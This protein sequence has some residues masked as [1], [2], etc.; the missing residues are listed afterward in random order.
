MTSWTT[1]DCAEGLCD[2]WDAHTGTQPDAADNAQGWWGGL[3]EGLAEGVLALGPDG[4]VVAYNNRFHELWGTSAEIDLG[5]SAA[6]VAAVLARQLVEPMAVARALLPA[7]VPGSGTRELFGLKNGK[8]LEGC[9]GTWAGRAR[10]WS[11]RDVTERERESQGAALLARIGRLLITLDID[12]ALEA[13]AHA[14]LPGLG[15]LCAIDLTAAGKT[16]R[17]VEVRL[18]GGSALEPACELATTSSVVQVA[19]GPDRS[20]VTVPIVAG[21]TQHGTLTLVSRSHGVHGPRE[22]ILCQEVADRIA[23]AIDVAATNRRV[24]EELADRERLLYVAAHELRTPLSS[25]R[26]SVEALSRKKRTTAGEARFLEILARGERNLTR[27]IGELMDLGRIRS[28]QLA[29]EIASVDL[30]VV[31]REAAA[32]M[33]GEI[34]RSGSQVAVEVEPAVVGRWDRLRLDQIVTNLLGNALK[35]GAGRPIE[36]RLGVSGDGR[37][38]QLSVADHGRGIPDDVQQHLFEPFSRS[39]DRAWCGEGLGLGL[40]IVKTIVRHLGGEVRVQTASDRGTT[41]IVELP[42]LPG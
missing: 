21:Q 12:S 14:L 16:V 22:Q 4:A 10:I 26:I 29:L 2:P 3:F 1:G 5:W 42:L 20:R 36:L 37:R 19:T 17:A 9:A 35:Y 27:M 7:D 30:G 13:V 41:F 8:V 11:F 25:L 18:A 23:L 31:V 39:A 40:Y 38:A 24:R 28:G 15:E 32:R 33:A 6:E 34:K